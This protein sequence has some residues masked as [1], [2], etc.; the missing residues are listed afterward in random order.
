MADHAFFR[1]RNTGRP[2]A[3]RGAPSGESWLGSACVGTCGLGPPG[4]PDQS[5]EYGA[6][7]ATA[8]RM[9]HAAFEFAKEASASELQRKA[10]AK[11]ASEQEAAAQAAAP[12]PVEAGGVHP[13]SGELHAGTVT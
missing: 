2:L 5:A 1:N 3:L 8:L 12:P 13:C 11:L 9:V 4:K 10:Q 6:T 7:H